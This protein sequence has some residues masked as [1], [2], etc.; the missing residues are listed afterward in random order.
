M[1]EMKV[2]V[3]SWSPVLVVLIFNRPVG[4]EWCNLRGFT[5]TLVTP[6]VLYFVK[7]VS[8]GRD[9]KECRLQS[10]LEQHNSSNKA[11]QLLSLH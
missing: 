3:L 4:L 11:M 8:S 7:V 2:F 5:V 1:E 6:C 10:G 9:L